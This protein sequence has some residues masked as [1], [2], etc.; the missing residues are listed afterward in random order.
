MAL[1][2]SMLVIR[3]IRNPFQIGETLL[4]GGVVLRLALGC[5][6]LGMRVDRRVEET[7]E[8]GNALLQGRVVLLQGGLVALPSSMLVRAALSRH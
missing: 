4:D 2:S 1:L 7:L 6:I 5:R 8:V 3:V